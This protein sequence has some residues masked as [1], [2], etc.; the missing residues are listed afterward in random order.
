MRPSA[1]RWRLTR[2]QV[3]RD[4]AGVPIATGAYAISFGAIALA[5]GLNFW[6]TMALSLLMFTGGSQFGLIG[7]VAAGGA[8]LAG[9]RHRDHAR[10][11]ERALRVWGC[12]SCWPSAAAGGCWPRSW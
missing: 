3:L 8:P 5:G 6:Q 4:A 11:P 2:S 10:C 12:P 7:V 1:P 9:R